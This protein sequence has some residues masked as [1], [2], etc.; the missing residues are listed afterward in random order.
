MEVG[1]IGLGDQGAPIAA[2]IADAGFD[3]NVWAR[4]PETLAAFDSSRHTVCA[5]L[6]TLGERCEVVELC[7][8]RDSDLEE[9]L[10]EQGLLDALQ[11]ESIVVNH[12]TGSPEVCGPWAKRC[13][14]RQVALLD[15]PV[16]GGRHDARQRTL[17]TMVGGDRDAAE[18]CR[19]VFEAFS[20]LVVWLGPHGSGQLVKLIVNA[21]SAA[22]LKNAGDILHM[23]DA[24]GL[25]LAALVSVLRSSAAASYALDAMC[26]QMEPE[27]AP[28]Y[29]AMLR[30][31]V[32]HFVDSARLHGAE[33]YPVETAAQAGA[34]EIQSTLEL[35]RSNGII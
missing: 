25:D 11:P 32:A 3:L 34:E 23:A 10:F 12:G 29:T 19:P 33:E 30:K 22:N 5:S 20:R 14:Q 21:L 2:A 8:P 16:S 1:F 17:T 18:R 13:D 31:D 6:R 15:A 4:R 28:H 7:L 9:V 27:L 35:L 26:R 24:L